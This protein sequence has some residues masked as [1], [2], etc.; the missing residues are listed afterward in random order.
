MLVKLGLN[1]RIANLARHSAARSLA[2]RTVAARSLSSYA[3]LCKERPFIAT[4]LS[5]LE[6]GESE[7]LVAQRKVRPISPHLTIYQPQLTW[8]LS[9]V[10]RVSLILLGGA[11]YV[12]TIL[13]GAGA[14]LGLG[15]TINTAKISAWWHDR[16]SGA[17]QLTVKGAAAYLF[18]FHYALALRHMVWDAAKE[19]TLKGVYRTG[20]GAIAFGVAIGTYLFAL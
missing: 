8:Y 7:L 10:H 13:F 6:P 17:T 16:V 11:F 12:L 14:L 20:Y 15:G 4:P 9:S 19:L 5:S 18:A 2:C 1:Q 3:P